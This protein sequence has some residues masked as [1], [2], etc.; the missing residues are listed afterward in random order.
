MEGDEQR[1]SGNIARMALAEAGYD[2][3]SDKLDQAHREA[4]DNDEES[5]APPAVSAVADDNVDP[6]LSTDPPTDPPVSTDPPADPPAQAPAATDPPADPAKIEAEQKVI[7]DEQMLKEFNTRMGTD[8]KSL[9]EL[10][11]AAKKL[12]KE[13]REA[14]EEK[15]QN[16]AVA[17]A[18]KEGIVKRKDLDDYAVESALTPREIA[19]KLFTE[20][21]KSLNK[22]LTDEQAEDKF[23]EYFMEFDEDD[24]INKMIR[25]EDM[26]GIASAYLNNKYGKVINL[27]DG[28]RQVQAAEQ[29]HASYTAQVEK[30]STGIPKEMSFE[31]ELPGFDGKQAKFKYGYT[32]SDD[33]LNGV[34]ADLLSPASYKAFG[35]SEL[36]EEGLKRAYNTAVLNKV[37]NSAMATVAKSYHDQLHA[38]DIAHRKNIPSDTNKITP[39]GTGGQKRNSIA[40]QA[41]AE[42]D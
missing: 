40:R 7:S 8:Y 4:I 28:Y 26:K 18:V 15:L 20:K 30:V 22:D 27:V 41:L 39:Q 21:A 37:I 31:L 1:P 29:S 25:S 35:Q 5:E 36:G 10:K 6:P 16:D 14:E 12:T 2:V 23:K 3:N 9:D 19:L 32:I 13:E 17:Y 38:E 33:I 24:S 11:P 34:K 42:N